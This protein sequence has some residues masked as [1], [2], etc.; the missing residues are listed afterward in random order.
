MQDGLLRRHHKKM[1]TVEQVLERCHFKTLWKSIYSIQN[2]RHININSRYIFIKRKF[3]IHS[4][5]SQLTTTTYQ[6]PGR[7]YQNDSNANNR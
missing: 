6:L 1:S 5:P 7:Y 3:G 2:V 4:I